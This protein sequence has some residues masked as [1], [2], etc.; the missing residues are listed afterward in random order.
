MATHPM[1][2][3][4]GVGAPRKRKEDPR[5]LTGASRFTDDIALAGQL[6]GVVVRSPHAHARIR[7]VDPAAARAAPGVRLVVTAADIAG[8]VDPADSL[9]LAHAALRHP[10]PRRGDG[11][12][13][14]AVP[15]GRG[16]GALCRSAR[17][18]RRGR[19]AGSGPGC[20]RSGEDRLRA[21]RGG[22]SASSRRSRP[23]APLVWD[24]RP[25]NVSFEW[26]GGDR[27]AVE[28]AFDRAAHVTRVE[29]INNRIAP[30]FMEPRSAV[31]E[32]DPA[33]ARW[34]LRVGCQSAHGMRAVLVHMMGIESERL[35][36]IVPDTGGGFGARGGVYPEYPLLLVAARR[37][38]RPV[39]W[40]AERAEAFLSDYQA[41]DHVLRGELALDGDGPLH[42][43]AGAG[44]LAPRRL[45]DEPQRVG[46]G[47]LP[48]A[49]P[50]RALSHPVRPRDHARRVLPHHAAGGLPGDRAHRGELPDGEPDRGGG[51]R[52]GDRPHRAAAA[53]H[54]DA[55]GLSLD[56][57]GR[58]R[59][60]RGRLQASTSSARSS[61]PTGAASPRGAR[62]AGSGAAARVRARDVRRERRQHARPSSPRSRRPGTA[63]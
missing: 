41:R 63:G 34:T 27:S 49:D 53:Q 19:D 14:R 46:D 3:P 52:D 8:E 11:A 28:A 45:S 48:A 37:L 61:W 17:R 26:E 4:T 21:A 60:D 36:V 47:A 44:R 51:P 18:V 13:G 7:A 59:R 33:A 62:R 32:Y 39:K 54:G 23:E 5:F 31:A 50:R 6:H 57:A 1:S 16:D 15:P 29:V 12:R 38:G 40:T 2:D 56:D 42:R 20:G 43:D 58:R 30:V 9:V 22:R 10:R 25:S 55:R 24:D 35:R